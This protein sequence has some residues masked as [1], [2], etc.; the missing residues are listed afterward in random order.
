MRRSI[1][2]RGARRAAAHDKLIVAFVAE[3]SRGKSELI[4]AIFFADFGK[5]CCLRPPDARRCARP[6]C[7][8]TPRCRRR[9][10][11]CRSKPAQGRNRR[12]IQA[13]SDEWVV[14]P[15]DLASAEQMGEALHAVSQV[16]RVPRSARATACSPTRDAQ[17]HVRGRYRRDPVLAPRGHQ[18][19]ASAAAARSRDARHARLNAIGA[20]P[21]LTLAQLPEAHTVLFLLAADAGVTRTDLDVWEATSPARIGRALEPDRR[22]EQDRRPVGPAARRRPISRSKCA[23][24]PPMPPGVLA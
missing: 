3:F 11:C 17:R 2:A 20:E 1:D 24:R 23:G 13:L 19:P 22:A 6:S 16:K 15:L 7:C 14:V 12:R 10:G 21:E 18:L 9:S 4:N 5:R 8:T